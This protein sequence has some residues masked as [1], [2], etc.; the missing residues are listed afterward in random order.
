[1][2]SVAEPNKGGEEEAVAAATPEKTV[3][4]A[5]LLV[6][7]SSLAVGVSLNPTT[8]VT[9]SVVSDCRGGKRLIVTTVKPA[10]FI[11]DERMVFMFPTSWPPNITRRVSAMCNHVFECP[12]WTPMAFIEALLSKAP[13]PPTKCPSKDHEGALD[14]ELDF[15]RFCS[16][17]ETLPRFPAVPSSGQPKQQLLLQPQQQ[18]L[19]QPQQQQLLLQ[20]QPQQQ[21][22]LQPQ[23]LQP[24]QF[25][26]FNPAGEFLMVDPN[27]A[28]VAL[29]P[30]IPMYTEQP[31]AASTPKPQQT[32]QTQQ[33]PP[34]SFQ[35]PPQYQPQYHHQQPPQ[36]QQQYNKRGGGFTNSSGRGRGGGSFGGGG[37][38][39][40]FVRGRS[41]R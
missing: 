5:H 17:A 29:P 21:Q 20:P 12:P 2:S 14:I 34:V 13:F 39:G 28:G 41:Q 6:D 16:L 30:A 8:I 19:L 32:Q 26:T 24:Q 22:L 36:Y 37:R 33:Q 38:G 11:K 10:Q 27:V 1:M 4:T 25:V 3:P 7:L 9:A 15:Q 23:L 40:S 35:P 31:V 18:Q